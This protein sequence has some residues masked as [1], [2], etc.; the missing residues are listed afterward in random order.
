MGVLSRPA[1]SFP[2]GWLPISHAESIRE[3]GF[4]LVALCDVNQDRL[5]K[6]AS[7]Y[8]VPGY[9]DFREMLTTMRPDL[10]TVA[11]RTPQK[12]EIVE[13]CKDVPFVYVE[14]PLA[15][16]LRDCRRMLT[17]PLGYGVNRRY[18]AV[19]RQARQ[20]MNDAREIVLEFGRSAL[21]WTHP[22]SMDLA[23]LFLGTD[24]IDVQARL[25]SDDD[26]IVEHAYIRF[27]SGRSAVI[28]TG[29]GCNVRLYADDRTLEIHADGSWLHLSR[30]RGYQ[31][32]QETLHS[33]PS[34]SATVTALQELVAGTVIPPDEVLTGMNMLFAC[35]WSQMHGNRP[36]RLD[37]VPEDFQVMGLGAYGYA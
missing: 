15:N 36:V 12:R 30:G 8:G 27:A 34:Q 28:T 35:V 37:E 19:Y 4:D 10:V 16:S 13:A 7:T 14:K 6:A 21:L 24:V 33:P 22:H 18:H 17:R 31:L 11:T 26:P 32:E 9:S 23:L 3:A 20:M 1:G 5:S 29:A 2:P 25:T